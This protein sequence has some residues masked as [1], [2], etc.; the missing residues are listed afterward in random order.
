MHSAQAQIHIGSNFATKGA[1]NIDPQEFA[2]VKSKTTLFI[3]QDKDYANKAAFQEAIGKVWTVTPFKIVSLS[4][5]ANANRM[6]H[7]FFDFGGFVTE[8]R[9]TSSTMLVAHLFYGMD[10]YIQNKKGKVEPMIIGRFVLHPDFDTYR[11][12][13]RAIKQP[14]QFSTMVGNYLH[15]EANIYNWTPG[16]L[17][18]YLKAIN[19]GIAAQKIKGVFEGNIDKDGLKSLKADTLYVPNY[20]TINFNMFTGQ[21]TEVDA[22][23]KDLF[24]SY[25]YPIRFVSNEELTSLLLTRPQGIKYLSY[26]KSSTDKFVT[27]FDSK[28]GK[29]LY[30]EYTPISYNF[31]SKDLKKI[32]S[33]VK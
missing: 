23:D 16:M 15:S 7:N 10:C 33:E 29:V 1:G 19:D 5:A 22:E 13:E 30:S 11:M 3:L 27:V 25:P 8:R 2:A 9:S 20:V 21:E 17:M 26:V 31:K 18:G 24:K 14:K 32:A 12:T 28:T 6:Q 4:E